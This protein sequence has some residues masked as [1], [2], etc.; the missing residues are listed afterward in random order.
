MGKNIIPNTVCITANII[1]ISRD[2]KYV[3][4]TK[5]GS[6]TRVKAWQKRMHQR[7][8]FPRPQS[9]GD[10]EYVSVGMFPA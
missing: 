1:N 8:K 10:I 4:L 6:S 3:R 2:E 5:T 9:T 7:N